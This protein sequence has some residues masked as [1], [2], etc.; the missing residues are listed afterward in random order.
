MVVVSQKQYPFWFKLYLSI[1]ALL[2]RKFI[3]DKL[4]LFLLLFSFGVNIAIWIYL[5][6]YLLL[7]PFNIVLHYRVY[8][9]ATIINTPKHAFYLPMIGLFIIIINILI[10][11][12]F[13]K[14]DKYLAYL[15]LGTM[16]VAQLILL[17]SS[18]SL[19]LAN[20]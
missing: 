3:N 18:V 14:K 6:I 10:A 13:H 9:G 4:N 11:L 5:R 7:D 2:K 15:T 19:V 16:A 17:A 20:D 8:Q 12:Y 1:R